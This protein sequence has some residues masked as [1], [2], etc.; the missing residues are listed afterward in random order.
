MYL[1]HVAFGVRTQDVARIF[2]RDTT[3]VYYAYRQIEDMRDDKGVDEFLDAIEAL[4]TSVYEIASDTVGGNASEA[5][6]PG[7]TCDRTLGRP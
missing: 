7:R 1:A 6:E 3:T 5:L 4:V 2:G